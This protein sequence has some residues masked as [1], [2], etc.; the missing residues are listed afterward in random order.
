MEPPR[1]TKTG[2]TFTTYVNS[3]KNLDW[4]P[5]GI[6]SQP[7]TGNL[8]VMQSV[9]PSN[10]VQQMPVYNAQCITKSQMQKEFFEWAQSELRQSKVHYIYCTN[11]EY[12]AVDNEL[13]NRYDKIRTIQ[14]L[15]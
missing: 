9:G 3:I 13:K 6:S 10:D 4:K 12:E 1:N 5:N 15:F 14:A 8:R 7:H 2:R 11:E